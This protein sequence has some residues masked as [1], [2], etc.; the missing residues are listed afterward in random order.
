MSDKKDKEASGIE[1]NQ[2]LDDG[3][4]STASRARNKTVM[5]SPEMTGEVRA[6][7]Q[8]QGV[9]PAMDAPAQPESNQF[10]QPSQ[11]NAMDSLFSSGDRIETRSTSVIDTDSIQGYEPEESFVQEQEDTGFDPMTALVS[12]APPLGGY[13]TED[14]ESSQDSYSVEPTPTPAVE[15]PEPTG[16]SVSQPPEVPVAKPAVSA[17]AAPRTP[18]PLGPKGWHSIVSTREQKG[19][20]VGLLV[21]YDTLEEGEIFEIR[22]GR[23]LITSRATD[24]G[25][26]LLVDD[27]SIS[28]LHAI[29]RVTEAGAIQVLDQLS[30]FGTG[31]CRF[32][33]S[34]E[35]EVAGG[36]ATVEHGDTIR[37]GKRY[38]VVVSIPAVVK[39]DS[40]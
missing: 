26:Y 16:F 22:S 30:E 2:A 19:R 4:G 15:T 37:F 6:M 1:E 10:A 11:P 40:K 39:P 33:E 3:R 35:E 31:L 13:A 9:A 25:D 38:F 21:S 32:G 20:L 36:L 5:L 28:P 7:L 8:Q 12:S 27:D 17:S 23:F 34:E 24:N 18:V 29:V 14:V